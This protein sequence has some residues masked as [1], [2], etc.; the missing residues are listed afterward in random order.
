MAI[1][2]SSAIKAAG[3]EHHDPLSITCHFLSHSRLLTSCKYQKLKKFSS[4]KASLF[5]TEM[6]LFLFWALLA[7]KQ[8]N[9]TSFNRQDKGFNTMPKLSDCPIDLADGVDSFGIVREDKIKVPEDGPFVTGF[10][11]SKIWGKRS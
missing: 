7:L 5:K 3:G 10:E 1:S 6:R 2:V 8:L 11:A 9:G 4:V